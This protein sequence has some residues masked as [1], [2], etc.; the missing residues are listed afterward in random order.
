MDFWLKIEHFFSRRFMA[1]CGHLTYKRDRVRAFNA[2]VITEVPIWNGIT[3]YCH[4]C[5]EA[6]AARCPGCGLPI[7]IADP[8]RIV[9]PNRADFVIEEGVHL[10]DMVEGHIKLVACL[11]CAPSITSVAGI[12]LPP[13]GVRLIHSPFDVA[14]HEGHAHIELPYH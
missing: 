14:A 2:G 1:G 4:R 11:R 9:S 8:V 3:P 7:F 12:W 6:M 5:L 10:F 13:G